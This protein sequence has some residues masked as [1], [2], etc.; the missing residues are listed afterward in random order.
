MIVLDPTKWEEPKETFVARLVECKYSDTDQSKTKEDQTFTEFLALPRP[1]R[2]WRIKWERLDAQYVEK[3]SREKSPIFKYTTIDL[4]RYNPE[5]RV[6]SAMPK[7][8]NKS[9]FTLNKWAEKHI[10]LHPD[11]TK[12]EGMVCEVEF[13]RTKMF[14]G[15]NAAKDISYPLKVLALPGKAYEYTGDVLEIEYDANRDGG[16]GSGGG[17]GV[18]LDDVAK[19]V[20]AG[21][22]GGKAAGS[23]GKADQF[24][25]EDL[26]GELDAAGVD[27]SDEDKVGEFVKVHKAKLS[28]GQKSALITGDFFT[29]GK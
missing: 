5:T 16:S 7:G 15:G 29:A 13:L 10:V 19:D 11:P 9:W 21:G 12:N 22:A 24:S 25:D 18:S 3:E 6:W 14:G 26:R 4:E 8:N 20:G 17:S 27:G 1:K 2:Q 28:S 23:G